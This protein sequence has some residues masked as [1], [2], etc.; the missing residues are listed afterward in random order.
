MTITD[1][2]ETGWNLRFSFSF[3]FHYL[4]KELRITEIQAQLMVMR[5][6]STTKSDKNVVF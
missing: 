4:F 5:K 1:R 3:K 6:G 2:K